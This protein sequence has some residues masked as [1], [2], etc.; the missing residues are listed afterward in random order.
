MNKPHRGGQYIKHN[1]AEHPSLRTKQSIPPLLIA[2]KD[3]YRMS[4]KE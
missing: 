1:L 3:E 2:E 4:N